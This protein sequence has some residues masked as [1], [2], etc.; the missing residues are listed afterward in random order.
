MICTFLSAQDHVEALEAGD[1]SILRSCGKPSPQVEV[2]VMDGGGE[3]SSA[4]SGG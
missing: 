1:L 2:A 3:Y 4:R